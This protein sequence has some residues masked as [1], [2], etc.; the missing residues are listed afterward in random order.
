[1]RPLL[2][3]DCRERCD[4]WRLIHRPARRR[5]GLSAHIVL[6]RRHLSGS[7][8]IVAVHGFARNAREQATLLAPAAAAAGRMVIAPHF[9]KAGWKRYQQLVVKGR[10]DLAL[11]AL[12]G[13]LR[14]EFSMPAGK[15]VLSGFSGGAQFAHR[16]A[17]LYP[18]L[19]RRL[20]VTAAGWYTFPDEAPYPYG[21][22]KG[23]GPHGGWGPQLA[24]NLDRF[25]RLPMDV[26]VG[27]FDD[28]PDATLRGGPELDR[29]QGVGRLTRAR[30]WVDAVRRAARA[31][32]IE[33][34]V[35]LSIL[36]ECAH[37]FAI[38]ARIAR[39]DRRIVGPENGGWDQ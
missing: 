37:D 17:M 11:L 30:R 26:C 34:Q 35:A 10:A 18:G 28:G 5:G 1:M 31:R 16:F 12:L 27:A 14:A 15:F 7:S 21:C 33:P 32:H 13:E 36:D 20:I 2:A 9:H 23:S 25:L 39:L 3:R 24:A 8:P 4:E 22:G 6:P 19:V 38:C 29:T